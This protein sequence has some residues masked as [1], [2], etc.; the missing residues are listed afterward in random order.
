MSNVT[1]TSCAKVKEWNGKPIYSIE[2]SDGVKGDSFATEIPIGTP[3]EEIIIEEGQ[4]G[5]K[6]K[7]KSKGGGGFN[8]KP[9]GNESFAL[10]YAKDL[11]V[12]GKVEIKDILPIADK[13]FN[14]LETKRK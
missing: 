13:L 3:L 14:W 7:L 11:V 10:S 9:K 2:L 1:V 5:K 12:S 8:S 4:Y 6:F